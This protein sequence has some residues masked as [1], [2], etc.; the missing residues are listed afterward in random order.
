MGLFLLLGVSAI[1]MGY[2]IW[3]MVTKKPHIRARCALRV[4]LFLLLLLLYLCGVLAGGFRYFAILLLLG[5]QAVWAAV[6]LLRKKEK[7]FAPKKATGALLGCLILYALALTPA[8]LFPQY[9]PIEP[10]GGLHVATSHCTWQDESRTETFTED[11]SKRFAEVA[12]WYPEEAGQYPLLVF[13]H[14]A[15]GFSGSNESTFMELASNGYVVASIGHPYHAFITH[16]P[17]GEAVLADPGFVSSVYAV[18]AM[19]D[20]DE[21]QAIT[22]G[23]MALRLADENFVL[24]SIA[25]GVQNPKDGQEGPFDKI[26]LAKIGLFGHSLG[27]AAAA[28]LGRSRQDVDAV[29]VLDATMLGEIVRYREGLADL[30]EEAYPVPLLNLYAENHY[31]Q[32]LYYGDA[33][34]NLHASAGAVQAYQAVLQGAGHMNFTDLPLFSPLLAKLLGSGTIEAKSGIET[35]NAW[36]LQFFNYT[37]KNGPEPEFAKGDLQAYESYA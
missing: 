19:E 17:K 5:V 18:N 20:G 23:W 8:V 16:G 11:G 4:G 36:L 1:E 10:T 9:T 13:S 24:D 31:K 28:E 12:F 26:D 33:Y 25:K 37:L 22:D 15:F 2:F 3:C 6:A 7:P 14:G 35:M 27:G 29:A 21:K 34:P 30:K 32:A